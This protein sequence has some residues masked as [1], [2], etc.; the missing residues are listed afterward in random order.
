MERPVIFTLLIVILFCFFG[1][2][3][4]TQDN[5]S[6][7]KRLLALTL[8]YFGETITHPGATSG[9]EYYILENSWYRLFLGG[10]LGGYVHIRNHIGLFVDA[11]IGN[12]FTAPFGLFGEILTG[13]GYL[14]T[15]PQ[16][17]IFE[18]DADGGIRE[19]NNLGYPHLMPTLSLGF[20][21]DFSRNDLPPVA[22]FIRLNAFGEYPFNGYLLPH[23][24]LQTGIS[25]TL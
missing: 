21:W 4:Y 10:N 11:E 3:S 18:R 22:Y 13:V 7:S 6:D 16:G 2:P 8:G 24:A 1:S 25:I 17:I 19:A 9:V 15:W 23:V 12:R 20:G 5:D 14:H